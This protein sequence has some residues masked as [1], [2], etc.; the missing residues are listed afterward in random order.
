MVGVRRCI[1]VFLMF[2]K[3]QMENRESLFSGGILDLNGFSRDRQLNEVPPR[4]MYI[5]DEWDLSPY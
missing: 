4:G 3:V 1:L 5:Y 2:G